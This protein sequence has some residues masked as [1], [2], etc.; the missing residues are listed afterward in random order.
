MAHFANINENNEVVDVVVVSDEQENTGQ[1]FLND[2][3]F[4]GTW[5]KTSYNT[6][7]NKHSQGK[8]PLRKNYAVVGGLYDPIKDAFYVKQPHPSWLLNEETCLW[9]APVP[10]PTDESK[11]W[12]WDETS[13]NWIETTSISEALGN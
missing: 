10:F 8:T 11:L 6:L 1:E 3:G 4:P 7:G 2:L 13:L 5:I 12:K 9:Q